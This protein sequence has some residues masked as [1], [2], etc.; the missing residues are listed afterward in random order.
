MPAAPPTEF[1]NPRH[2]LAQSGNKTYN[3]RDDKPDHGKLRERHNDADTRRCVDV[4]NQNGLPAR[5]GEF[6]CLNRL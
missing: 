3:R 4:C 2:C 5:G 1:P 6:F